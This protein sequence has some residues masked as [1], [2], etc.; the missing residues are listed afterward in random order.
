VFTCISELFKIDNQYSQKIFKYAPQNIIMNW[1]LWIGI[2]FALGT[3]FQ[4]LLLIGK[5]IGFKSS[6]T[7]KKFLICLGVFIVVFIAVASNNL[8]E[9]QSYLAFIMASMLFGLF[10]SAI[11]ANNILNIINERTVLHFNTIFL[12]MVLFIFKNETSSYWIWTTISITI[13][14]IISFMIIQ[15]NILSNAL[16]I[17]IYIWFLIMNLIITYTLWPEFSNY[18]GLDLKWY[19]LVSMFFI[20]AMFLMIMYY[21]LFVVIN[22]FSK[23]FRKILLSKYSDEQIN[24]K[25]ALILIIIQGGILILNHIIKL[26]PDYA[27]ISVSLSLIWYLD[28]NRNTIL[29]KQ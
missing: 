21:C 12:F 2:S 7:R 20:G 28:S 3:L 16:K 9:E 29:L 23:E 10:F 14:V 13:S 15:K 8:R 17:G 6:E 19:S 25:F 4:A 26:I 24:F 11:Y 5:R 22:L 1:P 27:L 18:I